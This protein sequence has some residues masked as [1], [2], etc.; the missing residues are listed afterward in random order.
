MVHQLFDLENQKLIKIENKTTSKKTSF[1]KPKTNLE[2]HK[3]NLQ[4]AKIK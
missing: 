1:E 4:K 3:I 2:N